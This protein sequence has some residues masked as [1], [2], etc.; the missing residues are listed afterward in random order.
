MYVNFKAQWYSEHLHPLLPAAL[1][2]MAH[3]TQKYLKSLTYI[4]FV[5]EHFYSF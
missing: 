2:T 5:F 1:Q 4:R 3:L